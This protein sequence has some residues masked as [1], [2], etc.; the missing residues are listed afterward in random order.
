MS[1]SLQ[2]LSKLESYLALVSKERDI[3]AKINTFEIIGDESVEAMKTI[4]QLNIAVDEFL[5]KNPE[6]NVLVNS[7]MTLINE[8]ESN[9]GVSESFKDETVNGINS[10]SGNI[11]EMLATCDSVKDL[12][13][14]RVLN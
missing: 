10:Y 2:Q 7:I 4:K 12:P 8:A 5:L 11:F 3:R 1:M 9:G 6:I 14:R 13:W